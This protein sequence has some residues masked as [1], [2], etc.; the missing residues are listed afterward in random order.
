MKAELIKSALTYLPGELIDGYH[1]RP[2]HLL[3]IWANFS[4]QAIRSDQ[5]AAGWRWLND[6]Q[7]LFHFQSFGLISFLVYYMWK[8]HS[9]TLVNV[10]RNCSSFIKSPY[11]SLISIFTHKQ[12]TWRIG[13]CLVSW[14]IQIN[15][16]VCYCIKVIWRELN[17]YTIVHK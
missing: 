10:K 5:S 17:R 6:W 15:I 9:L 12:C 14:S 2:R 7:E 4:P 11:P 13:L 3:I 16:L 8:L 1:F